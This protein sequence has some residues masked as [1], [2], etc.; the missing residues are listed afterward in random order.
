MHI[1]DFVDIFH[2]RATIAA[3][4][5]HRYCW[6]GFQKVFLIMPRLHIKHHG[7]GLASRLEVRNSSRRFLISV[8]GG[9]VICHFRISLS[10]SLILMAKPAQWVL[11]NL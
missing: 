4:S 1:A 3:L 6:D 8:G 11:A 10:L 5:C 9:S 2:I 7:L